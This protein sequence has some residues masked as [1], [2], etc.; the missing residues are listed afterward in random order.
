[1]TR[2][3]LTGIK[4]VRRHLADGSVRR[5]HYSRA[6]GRCFWRSDS[7]VREGS[8]AYLD[9]Y[10]AAHDIERGAQRSPASMGGITLNTILRDFFLSKIWTEKLAT[11]TKRQYGRGLKDVETRWGSAPKSAIENPA[12][13]HSVLGAISL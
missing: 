7:K 13:R 10:E 2:V 3:R 8:P 4:K 9:A 5:L 1:M 6:T 11:A 12:F